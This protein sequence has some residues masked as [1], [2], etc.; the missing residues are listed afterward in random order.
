MFNPAATGATEW[1]AFTRTP[2]LVVPSPDMSYTIHLRSG[3][4]YAMAYS[5]YVRRAP[6][7][8]EVLNV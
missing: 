2:P 3:S 7:A 4:V 1:G 6:E 5:E 8:F